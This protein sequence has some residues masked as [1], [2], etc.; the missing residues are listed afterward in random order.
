MVLFNVVESKYPDYDFD[1]LTEDYLNLDLSVKEIKEKYNI[2]SGGWQTVLKRLKEHGITMRGYNK[3]QSMRKAKHY[4][5]DRSIKAYRVHKYIGDK[6][7]L[8]GI[9]KTE[10]EAQAR[11]SELKKNGWEGLMHG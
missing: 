6:H 4:Y 2:T 1:E 8:F 3:R 9:Y 5:Y 11:V 7:Y 10:K